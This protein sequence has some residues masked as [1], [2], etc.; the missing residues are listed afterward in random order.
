MSKDYGSMLEYQ[1][2]NAL[3]HEY[4]GFDAQHFRYLQDLNLFYAWIPIFRKESRQES[5]L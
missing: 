4:F 3:N 5:S 2:F 1:Q